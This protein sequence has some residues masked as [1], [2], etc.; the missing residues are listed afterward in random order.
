VGL[1]S[2][3]TAGYLK[4]NA[5][6]AET[7]NGTGTITIN[8]T[9]GVLEDDTNNNVTIDNNLQ[10][11]DSGTSDRFDMTNS[12]TGTVTIN[13]NISYLNT[14][15]NATGQ[16]L[17]LT[18]KGNYVLNGS[19]TGSPVVPG[20]LEMASNGTLTLNGTY[21]NTNPNN[22]LALDGTSTGILGTSTLG[23]GPIDMYGTGVQGAAGATLLTAGAQTIT[24]TV[25]AL[26]YV[27]GGAIS[28][29]VTIGGSTADV[30]TYNSISTVQS[31]VHLTAVAGG[32]V[33]VQSLI[34]TDAFGLVKVGAG[35]VS[36]NAN[37]NATAANTINHIIA[38]YLSDVQQ[39]TLL[40][41]ST[42]SNN[43]PQGNFQSAFGISA[44]NIQVESGATLGGNGSVLATQK[45]VAMAATSVITAGDFG[46]ANLGIAPTFGTLKLAGG[47]EADSGATL[48]FKLDGTYDNDVINLESGALTLNGTVT[49]N[50]SSVDGSVVTGYV[51]TLMTGSG[52][53]TG[54]APSFDFTTPAGYV[55]DKS[56]NG[57]GYDFNNGNGDPDTADTFTV[58]FA[59]AP[60][61]SIYGML[62]LGLLAL[63]GICRWTHRST[64]HR[65]DEAR[66]AG[67]K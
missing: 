29:Y 24:N 45:V 2:D 66:S 14:T 12:G 36:L 48:D 21:T 15:P 42:A 39:G 58:E 25:A 26:N 51:Y 41:N 13:G 61:P 34:G 9:N 60:E 46:Q 17:I 16:D 6:S 20:R 49:V 7:L 54:S 27:G 31:G 55:L 52:S 5:T 33:N 50:F 38:P 62:G 1:T 67:V 19:F 30:S 47:L 32:R 44:G 23:K 3:V 4:F 40:V 53:W 22:F 64:T 8:T 57:T 37:N 59:L 28:G 18:G 10:I 43:N 11:N 35:T 56:Y 63:I 65:F